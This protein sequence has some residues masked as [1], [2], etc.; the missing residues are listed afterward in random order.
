MPSTITYEQIK[1][2]HKEM[3][4]RNN[5]GPLYS[6][7][8]D[9]E[10]SIISDRDDLEK[11]LPVYLTKWRVKSINSIY[12]KT[13]RK[14]DR[15]KNDCINSV[16]DITDYAGLRILCLFEQDLIIVNEYLVK[17]FLPKLITKIK[18]IKLFNWKES[19][20]LQ[21]NLINTLNLLKIKFPDADIIPI[22]MLDKERGYKSIHYVVYVSHCNKIYPVE[23]QAR[24]LLQ[25]VWG[26]LEHALVY[27][28]GNVNPHI[29][30]SFYLL[31][32]DLETS[33]MLM[34]HLRNIRDREKGVEDFAKKRTGPYKN[35]GY[36]KDL[37]PD[38]FKPEG[39]FWS[40]FKIFDD[41][42]ISDRIPE[43][44][45]EWTD[46]FTSFYE[47]IFDALSGQ[48]TKDEKVKY[49]LDA[50]KAF[51]HFVKGEF[52]EA[53]KKYNDII[54]S[55]NWKNKYYV[56]YFRLGEIKFIEGDIEG[57]LV[58]FDISEEILSRY[59]KPNSVNAYR[60]KVKLAHL[61]WQLGNEYLKLALEEIN[62]AKKFMMK[63]ASFLMS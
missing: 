51:L 24:T 15:T 57:A 50:E 2:Y 52:E 41:H 47:K 5:S 10:R 53:K 56:P 35:L 1:E 4:G 33:D 60:I 40:D 55:K 29:Q 32:R 62:E 6:I 18:T 28:R 36:E 3:T 46:K 49:W 59:P 7:L 54:N 30:K 63:I 43:N 31:S 45:V 58:D 12:L 21:E 39:K 17:E 9:L 22:N 13:K 44:L 26:E 37:I 11:K 38:I 14:S 27:K 48:D 61:Y 19:N 8:S 20:K 23:I 25:D 34:T 16:E 42:S